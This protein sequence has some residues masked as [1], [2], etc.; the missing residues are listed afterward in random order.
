VERLW[1]AISCSPRLF[2]CVVGHGEGWWDSGGR[3]GGGTESDSVCRSPTMSS[4][5]VPV[6]RRRVLLSR[7]DTCLWGLD[8]LERQTG[9]P[10]A[11][12]C[13]LWG[14]GDCQ[15]RCRQ[16]GSAARGDSLQPSGKSNLGLPVSCP[17]LPK[18][19]EEEEVEEVV[20]EG[21]TTAEWRG[22]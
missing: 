6:G 7:R 4:R 21:E 5:D 14:I 8:A 19:E 17:S 1:K 20:V 13:V 10:C 18:E 22:L 3:R 15:P 2:F 11:V 16:G 9:S 12:T